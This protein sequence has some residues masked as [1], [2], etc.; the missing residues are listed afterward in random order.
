[1]ERPPKKRFWRACRN[2]W[3]CI[4]PLS[5]TCIF[6]PSLPSGLFIVPLMAGAR[7]TFHSYCQIV[8]TAEQNPIA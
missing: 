8:V 2:I 5:L 6:I 4:L 1:M 7:L 3:A